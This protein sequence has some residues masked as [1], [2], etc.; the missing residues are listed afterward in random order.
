MFGRVQT[1][2]LEGC[3]QE[4][5]HDEEVCGSKMSIQQIFSYIWTDALYEHTHLV[6]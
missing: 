1:S 4:I 5:K 3:P 6:K 2:F